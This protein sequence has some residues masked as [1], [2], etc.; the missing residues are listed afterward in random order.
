[1]K[2]VG[3]TEKIF[4]QA[5]WEIRMYVAR[6]LKM[7]N[8]MFD[9]RGQERYDELHE[10]LEKDLDAVNVILPEEEKNFTQSFRL[11]DSVWHNRQAIFSRA[12]TKGS[13]IRKNAQRI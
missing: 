1:M 12:R 9:L 2:I 4:K 5:F 7:H 8:G 10:V 3:E 11:L 13:Q 6:Y